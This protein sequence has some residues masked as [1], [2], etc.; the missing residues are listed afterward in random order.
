MANRSIHRK[1]RHVT[2]EYVVSEENYVGDQDTLKC[3][4]SWFK[5]NYQPDISRKF[6]DQAQDRKLAG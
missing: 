3:L 4:K 5:G 6:S 2:D 1:A